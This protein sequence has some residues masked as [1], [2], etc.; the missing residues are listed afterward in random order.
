MNAITQIVTVF[1]GNLRNNLR[2]P[3]SLESVYAELHSVDNMRFSI[4]A[5]LF[6]LQHC[7]M[8]VAGDYNLFDD[9]MQTV[10]HQTPQLCAIR[11]PNGLD[12]LV[13]MRQYFED[14]HMDVRRQGNAWLVPRNLKGQ[15]MGKFFSV[16]GSAYP[17]IECF[18]RNFIK[19]K[20]VNL[21][22]FMTYY[23]EEAERLYMVYKPLILQYHADCSV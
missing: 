21:A 18:T 11:Y 3:Q 14:Y 6:I 9:A 16:V 15:E 17:F 10:I 5:S 22:T 8:K 13:G 1:E 2:I 4:F 7:I 23:I 20:Y 12:I 19:E